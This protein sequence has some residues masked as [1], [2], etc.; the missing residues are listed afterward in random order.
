ML[1]TKPIFSEIEAQYRKKWHCTTHLSSTDSAPYSIIMPPANVTGSLHLGH[2]LTFTI[3]DILIRYHRMLGQDV[4]WQPGTD[5]AGIATQCVVERQL[6]DNNIFRH[7]LG[8]EEFINHVWA[9]KEKSGSNIVRQLKQLGA[10]ALWS[11]ER[12]TMD[13]AA[14]SV[15]RDVF[16]K[17]YQEKIIYKDKRLINWDSKFQTAISDLEVVQKEEL[18]HMWHLKYPV[19]DSTTEHIIVATTRPETFFGDTAV[20]VHPHDERYKHMVG[21]E[22]L[23]P[24]IGR[25]IPIIADTYTDPEK[26]SGAV[27]ITPA[28]DFND[29]E[30]GKRHDLPVINILTREL[31][32]N[33]NDA[34]PLDFRGLTLNEARQKVLE[35]FERLDLLEKTEV[36]SHVVP[37][38]EKSDIVIEPYLTEQWFLDAKILAKPAIEAIESGETKFVPDNW[39]TT[40]F[41]WMRNIQPWCISRQIWWGHQ[42]PAWYGPDGHI[43]VA[44]DEVDAAQQAHT[45]YGTST[46]LVQD[47]DVLDTWFS[48]ALWPLTSLGWPERTSEMEKFYPTSVLVTGFDIIFFWVARMMMMGLHFTKQVPF[49]TVYVHALVCDQNGQKMSKSKGN[50]IDPLALI[51][52]YGADALRFSLAQLATIGRDIRAS[53]DKITGGRNF[54]TKLW[55]ASRYAIM[56]GASWQDTF[57][58]NTCKVVANQWMASQL[59]DLIHDVSNSLNTYRFNE[60]AS[61]LYHFTWG[62]FCD[63]YLEITKPLLSSTER[64][65]VTETKRT[66]S[67]A[68]GTLYHLLHPIIPYTTEALWEVLGGKTAL[69]T[70][71]WPDTT[72]TQN[73]NNAE[74]EISWLIAFVSA[75]RSLRAEMHLPSAV[76]LDIY[77]GTTD[78]PTKERLK[79]HTDIICKLGCIQ[80]IKAATT[81]GQNM[82]QMIVEKDIFFIPIDGIIDLSVEQA[83]L[84][85]KIDQ[86]TR[87]IEHTSKR[88]N[89]G[90][91]IAKAPFLVIEKARDQLACDRET[92]QK[93]KDA[94][95]RLQVMVST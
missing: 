22:I 20:A 19:A 55:N 4:L 68:L 61:K 62:A 7:E 56:A 45:H 59:T 77:I 57:D 86:C 40:Y 42:V 14:N 51:E 69:I 35:S 88:L 89:N 39:K 11:R 24:I 33:E 83:R 30:V 76:K 91:F 32:L 16:V 23:L 31:R 84:K 54:I 65:I 74:K 21:Q 50:V 1:E 5:H 12:F 53:E 93:N 78:I 13:A 79:R 3:Q 71:K 25:R 92:L 67:W 47:E 58:P 17:L 43:F 34:V 10:S 90:E 44:H 73:F 94:L 29:F 48:S 41:E 52:Q 82:L 87:A 27:K 38:G 66:I 6:N 2:A 8:R 28:H 70:G 46:P 75:V 37:Y 85:K 72:L 80:N 15:V 95:N 63:W 18:G 60:A 26:G 9:W 36:I 81:P 49:K 64:E